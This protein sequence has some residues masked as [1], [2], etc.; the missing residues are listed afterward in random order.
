MEGILRVV[1]WWC[2]TSPTCGYG[3][4][5]AKGLVFEWMDGKGRSRVRSQGLEEFSTKD[6]PDTNLDKS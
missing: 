5:S 2:L 3:R 4:R 6:L 1:R